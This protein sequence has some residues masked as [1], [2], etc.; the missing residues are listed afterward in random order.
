M[1]RAP[2][3][4]GGAVIGAGRGQKVHRASVPFDGD[5]T[6][7]D[8]LVYSVSELLRLFSSKQ[9]FERKGALD[10]VDPVAHPHELWPKVGDGANR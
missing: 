9:D 6:G 10:A 1:R 5:V 8:V 4:D 2:A 3:A 7:A